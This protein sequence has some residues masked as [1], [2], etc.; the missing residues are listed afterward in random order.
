MGFAAGTFPSAQTATSGNALSTITP[1]GSTVNSL[2][3]QCSLVSNRCTYPS[4]ILDSMPISGVSFG[5]NITYEPSFEKFVS[6]ANGKFTD[7]TLSFRDQDLNEIYAKDPN[8]S[9]TLI[10]RPKK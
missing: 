2:L 10:I 8:V 7:L 6:M 5:S 3:L 4:D 9:I 1:V